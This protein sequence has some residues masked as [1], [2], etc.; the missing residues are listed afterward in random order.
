MLDTEQTRYY[1]I[2]QSCLNIILLKTEVQI[3]YV[4]NLSLF[5]CTKSF[6]K[7]IKQLQFNGS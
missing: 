3:A 7:D 2:I 6:K 4:I 5:H 1:L